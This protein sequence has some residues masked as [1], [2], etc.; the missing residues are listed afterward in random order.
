MFCDLPF[1]SMIRQLNL[2]WFNYC[3]H[4]YLSFAVS[5]RNLYSIFRSEVLNLWVITPVRRLSHIHLQSESKE[6][7]M[8]VPYSLSLF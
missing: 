5:L 8:F 7:Q 6:W 1:Y 4:L 2:I 3:F